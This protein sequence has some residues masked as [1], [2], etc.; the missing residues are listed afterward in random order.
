MSR[1]IPW[2]RAAILPVL[3]LAFAWAPW[4]GSSASVACGA[5]ELAVQGAHATRSDWYVLYRAQVVN[6]TG[7]GWGTGCGHLAAT[8]GSWSCSGS[9]GP[10]AVAGVHVWIVKAGPRATSIQAGSTEP[11]GAVADLGTTSAADDLSLELD[12][13][14]APKVAG[15]YVIVASDPGPGG[16]YVVGKLRIL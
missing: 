4:T 10:Q 1:T 9:S 7:G 8:S 2:R 6:L 16:F 11:V 14:T 12:N 15:D 3:V 5:P 13:V